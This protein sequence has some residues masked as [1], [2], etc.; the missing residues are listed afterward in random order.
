MFEHDTAV[1]MPHDG[2]LRKNVAVSSDRWLVFHAE[3]LNTTPATILEAVRDRGW[4]AQQISKIDDKALLAGVPPI[5]V[6]VVERNRRR[7]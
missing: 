4:T 2:A 6:T 5:K 1:G 3:R 7:L